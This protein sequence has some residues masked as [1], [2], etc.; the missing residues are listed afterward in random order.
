M[1]VMGQALQE[2]DLVEEHCC[3]NFLKVRELHIA[4]IFLYAFM[5]FHYLISSTSFMISSQL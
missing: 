1:Y 4:L 3:L 2:I 5:M